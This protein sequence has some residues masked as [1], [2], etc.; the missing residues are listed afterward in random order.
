MTSSRRN[1]IYDRL[2]KALERPKAIAV[3]E[4]RGK[5]LLAYYGEGDEVAPPPEATPETIE[6]FLGA[7]EHDAL[8]LRARKNGWVL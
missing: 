8:K 4:S 5:W 3:Y 1:A 7:A 6:W 2:S